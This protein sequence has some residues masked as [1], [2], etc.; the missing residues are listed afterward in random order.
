MHKRMMLVILAMAGLAL[1]MTGCDLFNT[2]ELVAP[3]ADGF[4]A[5]YI[6]AFSG[7]LPKNLEADLAAIGGTIRSTLD[8]IGAVI[9]TTSSPGFADAAASLGGVSAVIPDATIDWVP[10]DEYGTVS[11]E[12]I[13]SNE[14]FFDAYQWSMLAIDAPGAWDAGYTGAGVRVAVCD[15]GIDVGHPDLSGNIDFADSR[16]F[17]DPW[18][19]EYSAVPAI[20]DFDGHGTHVA[21]IVAAADNDWGSI[22]VAPNA[23]IVVLKVLTGDG[24]GSFSWLL[25]AL[26]YA[27]TIDVDVLNMSLGAYFTRDGYYV[28]DLAD[29]SSWLY[30]GANEVA[31]F[32]NLVKAAVTAVWDSG[33]FVVASAGNDFLN[34]TGDAGLLHLP[35]DACS[36]GITASATGPLGWAFDP[37]T[38]LDVPAVYTNY[39]ASVD[40]AAP[41]GNVDWALYPNGPWYYDLVFSTY[42]GGWAWMAGTSQAAPH[43]AG[44]AALIIEANGGSMKPSHVE[45]IL[46]GTADDLGKPGFD[47]FYGHGRINAAEAVK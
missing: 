16:S 40:L 34:G 9:V 29:P 13:G 42:L 26:D 43:V 38:D 25:E 39:G 35:S 28:T 27:T 10:G 7:T 17:L 45:S 3:A 19:P 11:P 31:A 33:A 30:L 18:H 2:A 24:S 32:V 41:G 37:T 4:E 21:G 22:G 5:E 14:T 8:S 12:H 15:S 1:L 46:K 6:L 23:E 36:K 47:P 44:V 20:Q